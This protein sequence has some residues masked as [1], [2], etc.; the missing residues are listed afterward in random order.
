MHLLR[1]GF[2]FCLENRLRPNEQKDLYR[3]NIGSKPA[4]P[5]DRPTIQ[6][7]RQRFVGRRCPCPA[8]QPA[9]DLT[10]LVLAS[11]QALMRQSL[12]SLATNH[13]AERRSKQESLL[14][15]Q[16]RPISV[17]HRDAALYPNCEVVHL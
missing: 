7:H 12:E 2:R 6:A 14:A 15:F 8:R 10:P 13:A 9:T 11:V 16:K 5:T 17:P 1:S 4:P 3:L